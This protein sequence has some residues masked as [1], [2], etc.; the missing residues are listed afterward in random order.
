MQRNTSPELAAM[1]GV[2]L[3]VVYCISAGVIVVWIFY[4]FSL[5]K[6]LSRCAP[7]NRL[8]RPAMVWLCLVPFVNLV[9]IFFVAIQVPGSLQN[10]FRERNQDDGSDYGRSMA[11]SQTILTIFN[12][13][14]SPTYYLLG[15]TSPEMLVV[16]N[17]L[18]L[19]LGLIC[20]G[21]LIAFWIKI[22]SYSKLL[23]PAEIHSRM[24]RLDD[25]GED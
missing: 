20:F 18:S 7:H 5:Q 9:W 13:L 4:L 15:Y 6:A 19:G 14:F 23:A 12:A 24:Q 11:L 1:S 16:I 8:M 10:E 21:I 22:A 17:A 3:A 2:V 25:H